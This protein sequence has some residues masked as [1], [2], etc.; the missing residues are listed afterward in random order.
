MGMKKRCWHVLIGSWNGAKL[1]CFYS[2][3]WLGGDAPK[4]MPKIQKKEDMCFFFFY[5]SPGP[6]YFVFIYLFL[7]VWKKGFLDWDGVARFHPHCPHPFSL[8][9]IIIFYCTLPCIIGKLST[10][11]WPPPP[12][13]MAFRK[14][15]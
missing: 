9:R 7:N 11:F 13:S 4:W 12:P 15:C 3:Q 2:W 1:V 14:A 5:L 6:L 8:W 10:S